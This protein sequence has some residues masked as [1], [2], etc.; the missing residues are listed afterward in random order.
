MWEHYVRDGRECILNS[1]RMSVTL[2]VTVTLS[3]REKGTVLK[4]CSSE[5]GV[6]GPAVD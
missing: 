6:G 1:R 3:P 2:R 4:V 5:M